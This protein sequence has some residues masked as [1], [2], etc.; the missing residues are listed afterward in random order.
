MALTPELTEHLLSPRHAGALEGPCGAGMG[1]N[2][3]C[4][5]V[6]EVQAR[7]GQDGLELAWRATGC[8]AVLAVASLGAA[9]LVGLDRDAVRAFDLDARVEEAGGLDRRS[10]HAVKVFERAL[11]G[12]LAST[13]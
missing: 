5:D 13:P 8:G 12:A 1:E 11:A 2:A 3:A 6:L 7:F 10:S 4:G 9:E